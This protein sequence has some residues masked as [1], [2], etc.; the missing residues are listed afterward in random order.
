M[1]PNIRSKN[2][3]NGRGWRWL[4]GEHTDAALADETITETVEAA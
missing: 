1:L 2:G 3:P 4:A